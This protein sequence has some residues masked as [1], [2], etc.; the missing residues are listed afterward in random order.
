MKFVIIGIGQF[1]RAL[2]LYL[3]QS[4]F[5]VTMSVNPSSRSSKTLSLIPLS[6]MHRIF[7]CSASWI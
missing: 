4:G 5:E 6:V 1:G 7:A 3:A 2:A